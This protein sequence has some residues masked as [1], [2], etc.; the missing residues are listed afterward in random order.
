MG[1]DFYRH[2][3]QAGVT[4]V[5]STMLGSVGYQSVFGVVLDR[6][7]RYFATFHFNVASKQKPDRTQ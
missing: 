7:G 6:P 3:V 1:L 4:D 2:P 5:E